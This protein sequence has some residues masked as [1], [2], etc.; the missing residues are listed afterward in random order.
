M[1]PY[2]K[3]KPLLLLTATLL[4]VSCA[5]FSPKPKPLSNQEAC[6]RLQELIIDHS[7]GF[8]HHRK[9]KRV[10][11]SLNVWT[12]T[13]V[14]PVTKQCEVWEWSTGL[15]S[16]ICRWESKD[17]LETAKADYSEGQEII[18]SCLSKDWQSR[19]K[20]TQS[21]GEYTL[22]SKPNMKT[23]VEIRYFKTARSII[24]HWNTSIIISDENNL[25][26]KLQ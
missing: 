2:N 12:G 22:F 20:T 25:K 21:G 19:S 11:K 14:F 1:T 3:A 7:E 8:V 9:N 16:Y 15:F 10:L 4:T 13:Q 17:G 26:A 24:D 18:S 6:N 23:V 5:Q